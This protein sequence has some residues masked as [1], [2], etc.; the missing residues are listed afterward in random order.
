MDNRIIASNNDIVFF[1]KDNGDINIE[2]LIN[3]ETLW[4][5]Q[6]TMAEIFDVQIPAI[7]KHLK[8][9]FEDGEL[10]KDQVC[11]KM[12]HTAN[13]ILFSLS[14]KKLS[15]RIRVKTIFV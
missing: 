6:K 5:T 7:T 4:V 13:L 10:D 2:L 14:I 11:S 8:N 15:D 12:E 1:K 3:G 9:I